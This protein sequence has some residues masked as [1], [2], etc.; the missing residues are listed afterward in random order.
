MSNRVPRFLPISA[1]LPSCSTSTARFSTSPR[2]RA[3]SVFRTRCARRGATLG[4]HRRGG[5]LR[6]RP[7]GQ[8]ARSDFLSAAIAGDRRPRRRAAHDSG[9]GPGIAAA[10]AARPQLK[11]QFAAIAEAGP[12]IILEDKGYSLALHYRLAPDKERIVREAAARICAELKAARS[13][14][15]RASWWWRSSRPGSPRPRPCAN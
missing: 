1:N 10:A 3:R 15:C 13:S 11:R 9:R 12:G 2:R 8:R 4:P 5:R 6:E 7:A 14:C